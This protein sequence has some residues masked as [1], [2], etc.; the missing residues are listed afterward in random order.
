MPEAATAPVRRGSDE[1]LLGAWQML[2]LLIAV[3]PFAL[4]MGALCAEKGMSALKRR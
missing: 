3:V 4:I 1:F 2:P